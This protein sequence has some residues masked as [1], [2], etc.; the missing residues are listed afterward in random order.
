VRVDLRLEILG[1]GDR[2]EDLHDVPV[3]VSL[4]LQMMVVVLEDKPF[5]GEFLAHVIGALGKPLPVVLGGMG[6]GAGVGDRHKPAFQRPHGFHDLGEVLIT[7]DN[8]DIVFI[9]VFPGEGR[10]HIIRFITFPV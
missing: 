2:V 8:H 10:D 7:G 5:A 9:L 6:R 4:K 1:L 3:A